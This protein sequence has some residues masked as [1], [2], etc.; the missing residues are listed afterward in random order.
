MIASNLST[1]CLVS[2]SLLALTHPAAALAVSALDEAAPRPELQGERQ[3][4]ARS[5]PA[6]GAQPVMEQAKEGTDDPEARPRAGR[7]APAST[8]GP[9]IVV[10]KEGLNALSLRGLSLQDLRKGKADMASISWKNLELSAFKACGRLMVTM[11]IDSS[12]VS[13]SIS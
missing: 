1:C 2:L 3:A 7:P 6:E 5:A 4:P 11:A 12:T 8:P 9:A 10:D 13:L